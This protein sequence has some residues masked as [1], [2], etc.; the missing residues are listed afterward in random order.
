[1]A[2]RSARG[3]AP[4]AQR[5]PAPTLMASRFS[6]EPPDIARSPDGVPALT[7]QLLDGF[8]LWVGPNAVSNLPVGKVG[9]LLKLLL[10]Q[11]GHPVSR[12]R[13]CA[14]YW[15]DA[16]PADARNNL[17]VSL[18]RIRRLLGQAAQL[19]FSDDAYRLHV[20]GQVWLD[21]EQFEQLAEQGA[22]EEGR[23]RLD[24][25]LLAY[26][27]AAQLYQT[28][29]L[30]EL[31]IDPALTPWCQALR[32]RLS[33]VLTRLAALHE[34]SAD[35]HSCLRAALRSLS[36]DECNEEAHRQLMRCYARLH[37]PQEAERQYRRCVSVLRLQLGL[38][39]SD[40]TTALYRQLA[41]RLAA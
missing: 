25:A 12:S 40:T 13:L 35:Y 10:L 3:Q 15:P 36:L 20:V 7:V 29:L 1:M 19:Q 2:E 24:A 41:M 6:D 21:A 9:S 23:I 26:D 11:R 32:G 31:G 33:Q 8:R 16:D 38:A 39:P 30:A 18:H 28:D 17:N 4:N 22:R 34:T 27:A 37:Q 14:L 5:D